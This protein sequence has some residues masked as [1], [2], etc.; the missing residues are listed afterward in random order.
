[1]TIPIKN[2]PNVA[3]MNENKKNIFLIL[4][5][6]SIFLGVI[7]IA[8]IT[9]LFAFMP[10]Q[11]VMW[12]HTGSPSEATCTDCH[13]TYLINSGI[14]NVKI[15]SVPAMNNN[16]YT[17]G[18][19]Y[20]MSVTVTQTSDSLYA[21]DF[22]AI[23]SLGNDAGTL[24]ITDSI[25]TKKIIY[26]SNGRKNMFFNSLGYNYNTF[27]FKFNWIAPLNGIV[28]FYATGLVSNIDGTTYGDYVYSDSLINI[29]PATILGI[30][31][32]LLNNS[33]EVYP[34]PASD[35]ITIK[36]TS[37][38]YLPFTIKLLDLEGKETTIYDNV[39]NSN[40]TI[41]YNYKIPTQLPNG[42]YFIKVIINENTETKKIIISR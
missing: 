35:N 20:T 5:K 10:P 41:Y 1:M 34:N 26:S 18:Q 6:K 38:I 11:P 37:N 13:G 22:E 21:F 4:T 27:T 28:N 29:K 36:R 30:L 42:V 2:Y 16:K 7:I 9:T 14:G 25:H 32:Y 12:G 3:S 33:I 15:N 39:I 8:I 19:T 23:D 40:G 17:P 24:I 31:K